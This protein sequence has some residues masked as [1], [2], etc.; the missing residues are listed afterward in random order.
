MKLGI[1]GWLTII[2]AILKV[3]GLIAW[4]WWW[5]LSPLWIGLLL[6]VVVLVIL[7]IVSVVIP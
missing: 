1:A 4:S 5:V 3:T 6:A 7:A 2:F